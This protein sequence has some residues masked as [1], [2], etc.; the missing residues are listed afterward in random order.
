MQGWGV[1]GTSLLFGSVRGAVGSFA[2]W[3][4]LLRCSPRQER[5][6]FILWQET[7]QPPAALPRGG[8]VG[9]REPLRVLKWKSI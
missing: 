2:L 8:D 5:E 7:V 1:V 9:E 3:H 6:A 4:G